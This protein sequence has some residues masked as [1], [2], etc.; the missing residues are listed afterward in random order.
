MAF[1]FLP[2][3]LP[4]LC[5]QLLPCH[6]RLP[7]TFFV[8]YSTACILYHITVLPGS[9]PAMPTFLPLLH[10]LYLYKGQ[11]SSHYSY[12]STCPENRTTT[13]LYSPTFLLCLPTTYTALCLPTR[14]HSAYMHL[15]RGGFSN[16]FSPGDPRYSPPTA[17]ATHPLTLSFYSLSSFPYLHYTTIVTP[18]RQWPG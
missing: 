6:H 3:I 8:L 9:F 11:D 15:Y 4:Y 5:Y 2:S 10:A 1:S 12:P 16:H 13:Y 18:D 14:L 17:R 7:L